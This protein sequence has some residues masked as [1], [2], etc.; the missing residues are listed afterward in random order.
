M[1]FGKTLGVSAA[2][3]AVALWPSLA[4]AQEHREVTGPD[5]EV[6]LE[7]APEEEAAEAEQDAEE[8]EAKGA[9]ITVDQPAPEIIVEQ[10]APAVTIEQGE[11]D[12]RIQQRSPE[13]TIEQ[14]RPEVR[15]RQGEPKVE[16]RQA[17]PDVTF[18]RVVKP[19]LEE[20]EPAEAEMDVEAE[21]ETPSLDEE[22]AE[23]DDMQRETF[24]GEELPEE[25][26]RALE[27]YPGDDE[28]LMEFGVDE[29][30]L[31][32]EED[33]MDD[34]LF[35]PVPGPLGQLDDAILDAPVTDFGAALTVGGG[36]TNFTQS[37]LTDATG[38]GGYWDVRGALGT[39]SIVGVEAAYHG[40]SRDIQA[41]GL[42]DE[43]FLVGNGLEGAL[44]LNAPLTFEQNELDFLVEPFA[45][46]GIGWTRYN[47]FN[48]GVNTSNVQDQD[49]IFTIPLGVGLA[50]SVEGIMLDARFTY[51][52]AFG[53]DLVG[54]A[55]GAFENDSL[56]NWSLGANVG[57]EF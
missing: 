13:V 7:L 56:S 4:H 43:T 45:F 18:E 39:R 41:I 53:N 42:R 51:R 12:V 8:R 19:E 17:E 21:A 5:I 26:S 40:N 30:A 36:V 23:A 46:G 37:G 44:R 50:G 20:M 54:D 52:P 27:D 32:A 25:P 16:V 15:V 34:Q 11:P 6:E 10:P 48:E 29:E 55:T 38:L 28:G 24:M 57:F 49:D 33:G 47:L 1:R 31:K 35:E 3:T 22:A 14:P 9:Q 2:V